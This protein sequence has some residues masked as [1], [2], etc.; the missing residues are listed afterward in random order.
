MAL[1]ALAAEAEDLIGD[2]LKESEEAAREADDGAINHAMS[3]DLMGWEVM[4][5]DMASFAAKGKSGNQ[6]PDH[7]EQDGRSNVGRQ[8]MAVGE[9]AAGSGTIHEGDKN[10]EE[11]RTQDPTQGGQ[12]D[13]DGEADTKATGGGKQASGKADDFGMDGGARRMDSTEAGSFEGLEALMAKRAE[14]IYAKASLKNVRAD[15]LK[16]AA[17]HL[18]QAADAIAEGRPI[19]QVKEFKRQAVAALR[20]ATTQLEAGT[21]GALAD[22]RSSALLD[23]VVQGGPDEAPPKYRDLVADYYRRLNETL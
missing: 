19:D 17:H 14:T 4:E 6:A 13:L 5:G 16:D 11:R 9:T 2:L 20:R 12:V 15:S 1:G 18:R 23:G 10:I 3:D 7:K 22:G 8:G 21:S